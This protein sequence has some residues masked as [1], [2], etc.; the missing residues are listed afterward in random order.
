MSSDQLT[1]ESLCGALQ[2]SFS[3]DKTERTHAENALRSINGIPGSGPLLIRIINMRNGVPS[4]PALPTTIRKAAAIYL[5]N[6]LRSNW[7][8][9]LPETATLASPKVRVRMRFTRR[10]CNL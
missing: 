4:V 5:K 9:G 7:G 1:I 2:S 3:A 8:E 10:T 6:I